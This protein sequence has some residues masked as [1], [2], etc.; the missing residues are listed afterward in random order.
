MPKNKAHA[1]AATAASVGVKAPDKMP[2]TMITGVNN[3]RKARRNVEN[4]TDQ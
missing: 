2:P 1:Q 4:S 3:D